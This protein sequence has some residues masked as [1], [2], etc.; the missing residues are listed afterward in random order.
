[1]EGERGRWMRGRIRK[2]GKE[3]GILFF[4]FCF[5]F[6]CWCGGLVFVCAIYS[7]GVCVVET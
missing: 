4:F 2:E 5:F 7:V 6:C 1:M 3:R